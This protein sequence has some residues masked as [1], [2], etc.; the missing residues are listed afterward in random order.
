MTG[1][2]R[3]RAHWNKQEKG[4]KMTLHN[5]WAEKL[6]QK[7]SHPRNWIQNLRG[8]LHMCIIVLLCNT[9]T[10]AWGRHT[11]KTYNVYQARW[12]NLSWN[13]IRVQLEYIWKTVKGAGRIRNCWSDPSVN[14]Q[15]L[16][17]LQQ[18]KEYNRRIN[19]EQPAGSLYA[20]MIYEGSRFMRIV[21]TL[22]TE[23][24]VAF[25]L[26]TVGHQQCL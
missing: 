16:Q 3:H 20:W 7:V 19:N 23:N 21:I 6:P 4:E 5:V 25:A 10:S 24:Q 9:I 18:Y 2:V 12:F 8:A 17:C 11:G 13:T 15:T 1:P 22:M 14:P 26:L